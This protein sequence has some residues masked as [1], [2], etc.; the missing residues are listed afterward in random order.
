[1]SHLHP[2]FTPEPAHP[3]RPATLL[4]LLVACLGL[5][6]CEDRGI[7]EREVPKG[8]ETIAGKT[9][10]ESPPS[11]TDADDAGATSLN[12]PIPW[13]VPEGWRRLPE[14]G[15]MRLATFAADHPAG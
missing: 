15:P 2:R 8:I 5:L 10:T 7:S 14:E 1:M 12:D 6:G 3:R 9:A 11:T 4:V 13:S